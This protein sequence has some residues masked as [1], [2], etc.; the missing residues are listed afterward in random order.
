[1]DTVHPK[2]RPLEAC[3]SLSNLQSARSGVPIVEQRVAM[4]GLLEGP[5]QVLRSASS[6]VRIGLRRTLV[7]TEA[8]VTKPASGLWADSYPA[9]GRGPASLDDCVSPAF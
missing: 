2:D 3:A 1:G 5:P 6:G 9:W 8:L 7:R 4:E